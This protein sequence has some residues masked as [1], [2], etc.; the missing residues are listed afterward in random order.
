MVY[1]KDA[2]RAVGVAQNL[3]SDGP[4]EPSTSPG[5]RPSTMQAARAARRQDSARPNWLTLAQARANRM[6]IDWD[7]YQP[8]AP[9]FLGVQGVR[10]LSRCEDSVD[11]I[12]WTP[13]FKAWELAGSYPQILDDAVVGEAGAQAVRR[14]ADACSKRIID[15]RWLTARAA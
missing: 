5:S 6:Q 11:Y 9:T 14:R 13:F 15:E 1:V 12:D 3:V 8:A 4:R 10:R 2:S 7:S